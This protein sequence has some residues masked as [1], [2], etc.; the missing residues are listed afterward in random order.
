MKIWLIIILVL[1]I[2]QI[3]FADYYVQSGYE[4][5]QH[6]ISS[7]C[8]IPHE[9]PAWELPID[10]FLLLLGVYC[11][12]IL[13]FLKIWMV[14]GYR[15][16]TRTN[17]L[18]HDVRLSVL[19]AIQKNPGIHMQ[20]LSRETKIHLGTLRHHLHMLSITGKITCCQDTATIRFFE[21]NDMYS[22]TQKMVLKHLRN[23]TRNQILSLLK[24]QPSVGRDEIARLLG[25]TGASITWHMK[26]LE[27]D[28]LI[29][30]QRSG[31]IV[32]YLI[33]ED[34]TRFLDK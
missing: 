19:K 25:F 16:V 13:I 17:V 33:S 11:I 2:P 10:I 7:I 6:P 32:R 28:Q 14:L 5:P 24:N 23:N 29:Q 22:E 30:V 1:I 8:V 34:V 9:I 3:V 12:D 31:R 26:L 27:A 21:N 20:S 15:R 18:E 4:D